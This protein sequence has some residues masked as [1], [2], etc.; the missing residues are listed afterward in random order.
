MDF[1]GSVCASPVVLAL[2]DQNA[3]PQQANGKPP[4]QL[5]A[6]AQAR[7]AEMKERR[8][9]IA[10]KLAARASAHVFPRRKNL[11]KTRNKVDSANVGWVAIDDGEGWTSRDKQPEGVVE[12]G[13]EQ[14]NG[15]GVV[16]FGQKQADGQGLVQPSKR[17]S[18]K[19]KSRKKSSKKSRSRGSRKK[20]KH[21]V[22]V[23]ASNIESFSRWESYPNIHRLLKDTSPE[24]RVALL[25]QHVCMTEKLDGSNLGIHVVKRSGVWRVQAV[26]GRRHNLWC[27]DGL[28]GTGTDPQHKKSLDALGSYG[29]AGSLGA[30]PLSMRAFVGRVGDLLGVGELAVFGEAFRVPGG[31]LAS[32]HPFGYKLPADDWTLF[33]MSA[34][35]HDIF[36]RACEASPPPTDHA[37][38]VARLRTAFATHQVFPPPLLFAGR[39]RRGVREL[40]TIMEEGYGCH[41]FEG[42]FIV[43][44][45]GSFG[46]KWKVS[47]FDEQPSIPDLDDLALDDARAVRCYRRLLAVYSSKPAVALEALSKSKDA[48]SKKKPNPLRDAVAA[49][50][51][52]ELSK[53]ASF[54]HVP[55]KDRGA[56]TAELVA[57]VIEEVLSHYR[58]TDVICPFD[59]SV[60]Q[61]KAPQ[62]VKAMVMRIEHTVESATVEWS[63]LVA[64]LEAPMAANTPEE[65]AALLSAWRALD[66]VF[67]GVLSLDDD[68]VPPV[69]PLSMAWTETVESILTHTHC[70]ELLRQLGFVKRALSEAET[71]AASLG[72]T[73]EDGDEFFV[74]D[75]AT[76]ETSPVRALYDIVRPRVR[77]ADLFFPAATACP[78]AVKRKKKKNK[79]ADLAQARFPDQGFDTV[80]RLTLQAADIQHNT[81]KYYRMELQELPKGQDT[82]TFRYRLVT[83]NGRTDHLSQGK[84]GNVQDRFYKTGLHAEMD[85]ARIVS[86]KRMAGYAEVDLEPAAP[87]EQTVART[88][89]LPPST[90]APPVSDIVQHLYAEAASNLTSTFNIT[91]TPRGIEGPLGILSLKQLVK[92]ETVLSQLS[93]VLRQQHSG[94]PCVQSQINEL[95]NQ[96]FSLIP[97]R[98][99]THRSAVQSHVIDNVSLLNTRR[100]T[101]QLMKDMLALTDNRNADHTDLA[102]VDLQYR[103]LNCEMKAVERNTPAFRS[104]ETLL[105][106]GS[107]RVLQGAFKI[108]RSEERDRFRDIGNTKLLLHGS[109]PQNFVGILSRGILDPKEV[110]DVFHI[111]RSDF[112]FLGSGIYFSDNVSRS[113]QYASKDTRGLRVLVVCKVALGLCK[114]FW[115]L[116]PDLAAPPSGYNSTQGV[117]ATPARRSVFEHDEFVVYDTSLIRQ[118]YLVLVR[119]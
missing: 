96:F 3:S 34:V 74:L 88:S 108:A 61:A 56:V 77:E 85:F 13:Q 80:K 97:H 113:L 83:T 119:D 11:P 57:P 50:F 41:L 73:L 117:G 94:K 51:A 43:A 6:M 76:V 60:L 100:E 86:D 98:L 2:M 32:W 118:E 84:R 48:V 4:P 25:D 95:S 104:L 26:M 75:P 19:T 59:E 7:Q 30:L 112:G 21:T 52:R 38:V 22:P 5:S 71:Q 81:N 99:G 115:T 31:T 65:R 24:R 54:S 64:S 18:H 47:S 111:E 70:V 28:D 46:C 20:L 91:I 36:T 106:C 29:N 109:R 72:L 92:G 58:G 105:A 49:A 42:A 35:V 53:R 12:F 79:Q 101:L 103:A 39:L 89:Q 45:D 23:A 8:N 78:R 82:Y 110:V 114:R 27:A 63:D 10:A 87:T 68:D 116:S 14:A 9:R 93:Q 66:L 62:L 107:G 69:H 17:R 102:V 37:E 55:R 40:Q 1:I 44:E 16:E 33:R 67:V 15:Q 90:L